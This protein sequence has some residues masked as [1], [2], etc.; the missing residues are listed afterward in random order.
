MDRCA[1]HDLILEAL[2]LS[3]LQGHEPKLKK[4]VILDAEM[5]ACTGTNIDGSSL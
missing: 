2:N 1:I 5:V 3:D 4:N